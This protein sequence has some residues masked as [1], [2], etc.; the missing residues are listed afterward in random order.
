MMETDCKKLRSLLVLAVLVS[1][2][3][4]GG[5]NENHRPE[6]WKAGSGEKMLETGVSGTF[7]I[8]EGLFGTGL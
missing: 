1:A 7:S 5:C 2:G 3:W 8:V 6:A 4:H